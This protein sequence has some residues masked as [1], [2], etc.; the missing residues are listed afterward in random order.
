[1]KAILKKILSERLDDLKK[2]KDALGLGGAVGN[3]LLGLPVKHTLS[4]ALG[5]LV[6]G[7]FI[8]LMEGL[9]NPPKKERA[10]LRAKLSKLS[11]KVRR[12]S[13]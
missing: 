7:L 9:L 11:R 6:L 2:V 4:L 3:L 5:Y 8:S 1:M 10:S 12:D 13:S